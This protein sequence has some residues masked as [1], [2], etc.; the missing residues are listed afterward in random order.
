MAAPWARPS[1][2]P[3]PRRRPCLTLWQWLLLVLFHFFS[4]VH[5]AC[6]CAVQ[7]GRLYFPK[8]HQHGDNLLESCFRSSS[9]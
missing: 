2:R 3:S 5:G 7:D 1:R 8:A 9:R 6:A 4:P